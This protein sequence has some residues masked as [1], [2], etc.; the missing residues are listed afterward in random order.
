MQEGCCLVYLVLPV[1]WDGAA[2]SPLAGVGGRAAG[3]RT[4]VSWLRVCSGT[5]QSL[6]ASLCLA[7][8]RREHASRWPDCANY[9]LPDVGGCGCGEG[10][11]NWGHVPERWTSPDQSNS[12]SFQ[13]ALG[14]TTHSRRGPAVGSAGRTG[15][16][17]GVDALSPT[18]T[19]PD[20][21]AGR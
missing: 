17:G 13:Q 2:L 20:T 16:L 19:A 7:L 6:R 8:L 3:I 11:G 5:T 14:A 21:L 12:S 10:V 18:G 15:T 9:G 1:H 4:N